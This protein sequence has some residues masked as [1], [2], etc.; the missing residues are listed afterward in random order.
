MRD[1]VQ[2]AFEKQESS[3]SLSGV[4][5]AAS[6]SADGDNPQGVGITIP[7]CSRRKKRQVVMKLEEALANTWTVS[8]AYM[9]HMPRI[10]RGDPQAIAS[11]AEACSAAAGQCEALATVLETN[12]SKNGVFEEDID[13]EKFGQA[14]VEIRIGGQTNLEEI[15]QL[16]APKGRPGRPFGCQNQKKRNLS[17][18]PTADEDGKRESQKRQRRTRKRKRQDDAVEE[19]PDHGDG[20]DEDEWNKRNASIPLKRKCEIVEFAKEL[21]KSDR[22][23]H[24]EKEVV[25]QFPKEFKSLESKKGG[26][27]SGLLGKWMRPAWVNM[28]VAEGYIFIYNW[29]RIVFG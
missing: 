16:P 25:A 6:S 1:A 19:P 17:T 3:S 28:E 23:F 27:K 8:D 29:V 26:Y 10:L 12:G 21:Q 4:P 14:L 9:Q 22:C 18:E 2:A 5:G 7:N 15:K 24:I 11:F 20:A 13:W